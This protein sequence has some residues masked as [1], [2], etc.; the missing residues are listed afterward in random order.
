MLHQAAQPMCTHQVVSL[1]QLND[2]KHWKP[3]VTVLSADVP[4][5]P[6]KLVLLK[7]R[8]EKRSHVVQMLV[9]LVIPGTLR[10]AMK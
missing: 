1:T 5:V 4:S 2:L 10:V 9:S 8:R 3:L 6:M 7:L